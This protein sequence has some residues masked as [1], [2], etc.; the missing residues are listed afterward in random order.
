MKKPVKKETFREKIQALPISDF[1]GHTMFNRL[2]T[3]QK[4]EWI[5]ESA[6]FW[7]ETRG[8]KKGKRN[9]AIHRS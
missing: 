5:S 9:N 6:Q 1:D 7:F 4:L 2:S 3:E 8:Y